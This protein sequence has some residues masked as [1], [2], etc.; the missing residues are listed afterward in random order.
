MSCVNVQSLISELLDRRLAGEKREDVLQHLAGCRACSSK[1]DSMAEVRAAMRRLGSAPVPPRLA[2]QLRIAASRER[3]RVISRGTFGMRWRYWLELA[4]LTLDNLMR[5]L[6]LP[7]AGGVLSAFVLFS[8]LVPTFAI[9]RNYVNDVP[10]ALFTDPTLEDLGH[11]HD[12]PDETTLELT[13]DERGRV[14][15]FNVPQGKLTPE[16]LNDLLFYRFAP[17]TAFGFPTWGKV[18]V[19]FRRSAGGSQ[20][21]VRG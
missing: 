16:M 3:L 21:V 10:I 8:S 2:T 13:V 15:G 12:T 9:Q 1:M 5:P 7:F 20:I 4:R 6:A 18:T 11:Y 19:T 17:A 14:T